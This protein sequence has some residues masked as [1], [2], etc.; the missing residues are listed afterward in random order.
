MALFRRNRESTS[1]ADAPT[2]ED[3][4]GATPED[5]SSSAPDAGASAPDATDVVEVPGRGGPYDRSQV[6]QPGEHLDLGSLWLI[7]QPGMQVRLDVDAE[8]GHF[9]CATVLLSGS[10]MQLQ[11][12]AAP[13]SSGT[14]AEIR[15]EIADSVQEQ[16]GTAEDTDGPWGI[17][18]LA[19]LPAAGPGG[20]TIHQAARFIGVDGP[21][22]FLRAVLTG[23]AAAQAT[24]AQPFLEVIRSAV[25]VRGEAAMAPRELL[26]LDLP[27][28]AAEEAPQ[29][30]ETFSPFERGPEITEIR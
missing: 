21:R 2:P 17:E 20:E 14:W 24:L 4:V 28:A 27:T 13:R 7:G 1:Q 25:V 23:P 8:G 12:F 9:S 26:P 11:A 15:Q 10:A 19:R 6:H 30:E 3:S 16:G 5:L 22:W 18:L 29:Q